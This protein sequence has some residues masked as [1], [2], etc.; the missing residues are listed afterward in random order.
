MPLHGLD[1]RGHLYQG[2]FKSFPIQEDHHLLCVLRYV[3]AN[4][5]R[6]RPVAGSS[7]EELEPVPHPASARPA[8]ESAR[9]GEFYNNMMSCELQKRWMPPFPRPNPNAG[10]FQRFPTPFNCPLNCRGLPRCPVLWNRSDDL[11]SLICHS[12]VAEQRLRPA[13]PGVIDV[14]L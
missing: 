11:G 1:G 6:P 10:G 3:E 5:L 12:C 7:G 14:Y 8:E 2:R 13:G 4:A 9:R